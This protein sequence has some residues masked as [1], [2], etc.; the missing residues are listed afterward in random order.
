M[1]KAEK[2]HFIK[3]LKVLL[4]RLPFDRETRKELFAILDKMKKFRGWTPKGADRA[5]INTLIMTHL[6]EDER[7]WLSQHHVGPP[8]R[9]KKGFE[10]A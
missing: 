5:W 2:S 8:G 3:C 6:T 7:N 4:I 9:W 10:A 1:S